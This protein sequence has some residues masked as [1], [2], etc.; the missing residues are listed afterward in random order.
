MAAIPLRVLQFVSQEVNALSYDARTRVLRVLEAI[1]W[2]PDNI[3]ES[4]ELLVQ[5]ISSVMPAYTDAAAQAGADLYD[6]VREAAAGEPIG[7]I[8]V[9]GYEPDATDGA[10]RAFVQDIVDGGPVE[11]FNA[12]VLDRVDYEIRRAENVSVAE[13]A[14]RD[15]LRPRYARVP[16]GAET[17]PFCLML[18]SR[19]FAYTSRDAASHAHP[20]CDCR[21]VQGYDGMEVE[22]Y[23]PDA[24][25]SDYLDGEFGTFANKKRGGGSR[26]VSH[27][28][29]YKRMGEFNDRL[30]AAKNLEELYAVGD[31]ASAWFKSLRFGGD[32]RSRERARDTVLS[33][34]RSTAS[35]RHGELSIGGKPGIVTYTKPRSELLDHERTGI[36]WLASRGFDIETIP[37]VGDA[38]A[39]LDIV[40]DGEEWEMKNVSNARG[41]VSN[42]MNRIRGKWRK[43]QRKDAPRGVITCE[44]C[45][46]SLDEVCD[47]IT[48]RIRDGERYLVVYSDGEMRRVEK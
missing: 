47:G 1:E 13:N 44:G 22:G 34:L 46:A 48:L 6:V 28:E 2:T 41:S 33:M 35:R 4:R 32:K 42:Q 40:M 8:A 7:A 25:Y 36:D 31:E 5:A 21:V 12:K 18:A 26:T 17:C 19:G 37:E 27:A 9:S 11:Q 16:T 14:A 10:V 24:L 15:P 20:N 39:N 43:L 29:A 30:R 23:D 3:T 38:P 45:E